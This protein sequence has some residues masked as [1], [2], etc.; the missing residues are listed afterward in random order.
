MS[1]VLTE[2]KTYVGITSVYHLC[3]HHFG[4]LSDACGNAPA[5]GARDPGLNPG[6]DKNFSLKI[7]NIGTADG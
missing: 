2:E 3:W 7:C 1:S 4:R 6:P 5:R